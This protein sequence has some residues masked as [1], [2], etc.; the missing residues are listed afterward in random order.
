MSAMNAGLLALADVREAPGHEVAGGL[1]RRCAGVAAQAGARD[2][3]ADE[4]PTRAE[5]ALVGRL[6]T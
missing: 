3:G 6:R 2:A 1:A 4:D 5:P